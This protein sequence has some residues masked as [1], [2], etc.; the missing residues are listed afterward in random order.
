MANNSLR[1]LGFLTIPKP[2]E[3]HTG[4]PFFVGFKHTNLP[5]EL[6]FNGY[7]YFV[8]NFG[9]PSGYHEKNENELFLFWIKIDYGLLR[10]SKLEL[11]TNFPFD[12]NQTNSEI[13]VSLQKNGLSPQEYPG[14][15]SIYYVS[16]GVKFTLGFNSSDIID[17]MIISL[18]NN[19]DKSLKKIRKN[20]SKQKSNIFKEN[21]DKLRSFDNPVPTLDW[22]YQKHIGSHKAERLVTELFLNYQQKL[23]EHTINQNPEEIYNSVKS[24]VLGLNNSQ[25]RGLQIDTDEREL[26]CEMIE[27]LLFATGFDSNGADLTSEWRN[28]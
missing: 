15:G 10:K 24:I 1:N 21:S 3:L 8:G 12:L 27:T 19:H 13:F 26:L 2:S 6:K 11:D 9:N 25:S 7:K 23:I 20:L 5:I 14:G 16:D 17:L 18:E 28:W 4:V 22:S